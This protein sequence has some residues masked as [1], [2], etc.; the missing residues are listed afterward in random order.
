[1]TCNWFTVNEIIEFP[2]L[3]LL[4]ACCLRVR[5]CQ[6]STDVDAGTSDNIQSTG[7]DALSKYLNY[8]SAYSHGKGE[9]D[10]VHSVW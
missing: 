2:W 6:T 3:H 5:M 7:Q 4:S 8:L 10:E 9:V 1:M